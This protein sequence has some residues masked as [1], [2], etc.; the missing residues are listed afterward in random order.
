MPAPLSIVIP[1]L[2][3]ESSLPRLLEALIEGLP[4]GLI[5]EVIVSDGG[6]QDATRAIAEAAGAQVLNGPP[7]RGGQLRHGC[8]AARGD[9][10]LVLHADTLPDPGWAGVVADHI[11]A[12]EDAACFRLAFRARGPGAAWVAGWANLRTRLFGLPYG[13]Q[14]LLIRRRD[15]Q[16]AGG[17]PDQLLM[18]DVH[19]VRALSRAPVLLPHRAL[20]GAE[21]YLRSGWLRRG[22]RNLWTLMRYFAGTDPEALARAYRR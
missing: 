16:T 4:N 2:Q 1:T 13:D 22:A 5:R 11:A 20:T 10:L 21:R 19:L 14:G 12:R 3:A 7:S 15:Y 9:W 8:D 6:S 18:E 17:Y